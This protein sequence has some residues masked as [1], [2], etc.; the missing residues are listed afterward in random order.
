M[1]IT[2]YL[3]PRIGVAASLEVGQMTVTR[4][5]LLVFVS[6]NRAAFYSG[7]YKHGWTLRQHSS[8]LSY[9]GAIV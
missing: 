3:D 5:N 9:I 2:F 1:S 6:P 7:S 4:G 8:S